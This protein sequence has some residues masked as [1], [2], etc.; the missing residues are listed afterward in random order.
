MSTAEKPRTVA[1]IG[2]G[3][4]GLATGC[5]AQMNGYQTTIFEQHTIPGGSARPG[6]GRGTPSM[7]AS[8]G[9]WAPAPGRRFAQR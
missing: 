9:W 2:A 7:A 4:A 3:I 1:I 6:N 5:Y 8:T